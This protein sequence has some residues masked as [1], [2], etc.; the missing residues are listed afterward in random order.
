MENFVEKY[1]ELFLSL[2]E[3]KNMVLSTSLNDYVASRTMSIII[4]D[5]RLYFQTDKASQK[6]SQLHKNPNVSLCMDNIQIEGKCVEIGI[7]TDNLLFCE[8]Y[9]KHFPTAYDMYSRLPNERLF[10]VKPLYIKKWLY[11]DGQPYEELFQPLKKKYER[12]KYM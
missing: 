2:G 3:A 11:V 4:I 9:K 5:R 1:A 6:Y 7:P 8:L 12:R 10:C